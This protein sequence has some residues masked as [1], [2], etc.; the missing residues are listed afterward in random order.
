MKKIIIFAISLSLLLVFTAPV[1]A[2]TEEVPKLADKTAIAEQSVITVYQSV[3]AQE[4]L[5]SKAEID[6]KYLQE[7][8]VNPFI[9]ELEAKN[10]LYATTEKKLQETVDQINALKKDPAVDREILKKLQAEEASLKEQIATLSQEIADLAVK[11]DEENKRNEEAIAA[12]EKEIAAIKADIE[13]AK[14]LAKRDLIETLKRYSVYLGIILFLVLLGNIAKRAIK[15]QGTT[16]SAKRLEVFNRTINILVYSLITIIIFAAFFSKF[17][18]F[19]PFLAIL[20]TGLAF[21]VRDVISSF[22]AW[23]FIGTT[24]GF[25]IG[26]LIEIGGARGRVKEVKLIHT[27]LRETGERGP[28]GKILSIPNKFIFQ[29]KVR[30]FSAMYRFTWVFMRFLLEEGTNTEKAGRIMMEIILKI[31]ADDLDDIRKNLPLLATKFGLSEDRIA[32]QIFF[33]LEDRGIR[34]EAKFICRLEQR[35]DLH[36][37]ITEEFLKA[38][39]KEDNIKLRFTSA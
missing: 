28:T 24:H 32:P 16:L 37:L 39:A 18:N 22:L 7:Q 36:S 33:D 38:I 3:N 29:E 13:K 9:A 1:F 5:L 8:F 34:M 26:D 2:A 23:F 14:E 20:G 35:H 27:I 21:A 10:A 25:K 17:A 19:L 12:K 31:T 4:Q 11:R 15:R 30:N 6:L